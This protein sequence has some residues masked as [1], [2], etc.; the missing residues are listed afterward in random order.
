M[1]YRKR[2]LK[3]CWKKVSASMWQN[4]L[5]KIDVRTDFMYLYFVNFYSGLP[6]TRRKAKKIVSQREEKNETGL[7]GNFVVTYMLYRT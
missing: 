5:K 7:E 3:Q 6:A 2:R 4:S 1:M